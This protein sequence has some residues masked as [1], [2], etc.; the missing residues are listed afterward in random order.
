MWHLS[1]IRSTA[2][3]GTGIVDELQGILKNAGVE[4]GVYSNVAGNPE[5][6]EVM[7]PAG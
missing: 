4:S 3:N 7:S 1:G 5:E 6:Y 2:L